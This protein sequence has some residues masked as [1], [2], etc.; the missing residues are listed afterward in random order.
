[1]KIKVLEQTKNRLKFELEGKTHTLCNAIS[2]E[3]WN[4]KDVAVAGYHLEHPLISNAAL[5][6]EVEKGDPKKVLLKAVDRLTK[7]NKEYLA[8]VKKAAK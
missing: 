3:L 8:Q 5:V 6:V 1:M 4:D 7:K 2:S